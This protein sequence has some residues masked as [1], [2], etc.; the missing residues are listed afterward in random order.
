M[1]LLTLPYR[2]FAGA[3]RTGHLV[4]NARVA[5]SVVDVFRTL[6]AERFPIRSMRLVDE[7][8]GDDDRSMAA[9]NTSGFN[10]RNATGG[11]GWSQHAYGLAVDVNPREN[12]YVYGSTVLPPEGAA[13]LDRS[14]HRRGMAYPGSDPNSA[15]AREGWSWGGRWRN[16]DYQHFSTSGS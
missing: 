16:P 4:V 11:S 14:D 13:Y 1:R 5:D 3:T 8:G 9:D 2:D 15:F 10:C 12:P 6:Y 7:F